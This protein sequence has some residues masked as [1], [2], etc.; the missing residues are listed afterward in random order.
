MKVTNDIAK[1]A[2]NDFYPK[3]ATQI[4]EIRDLDRSLKD[5]LDYKFLSSPKTPQDIAGLIDIVYK[6]SK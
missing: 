5:A 2:V 4:G 6:P 3:A 1:Q